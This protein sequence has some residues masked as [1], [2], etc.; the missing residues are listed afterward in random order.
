MTTRIPTLLAAVA[1]LGAA[2]MFTVSAQAAAGPGPNFL[3][4]RGYQQFA[5]SSSYTLSDS[6]SD[7]NRGQIEAP[8]VGPHG[9]AVFNGRP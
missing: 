8:S 4:P 9:A 3:Q 2:A 7:W 5:Y 1:A 6:R